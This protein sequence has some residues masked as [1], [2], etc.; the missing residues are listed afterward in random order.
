MCLEVFCLTEES[1]IE[2]TTSHC[3]CFLVHHKR[4]VLLDQGRWETTDWKNAEHEGKDL[5]T[6][7]RS[8]GTIEVRVTRLAQLFFQ[9]NVGRS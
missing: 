3:T 8:Q 5:V 1:E 4:C 6:F 9:E 2:S 7:E